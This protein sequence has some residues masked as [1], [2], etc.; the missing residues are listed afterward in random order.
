MFLNKLQHVGLR[1]PDESPDLREDGPPATYA[2]GLKG[3]DRHGKK[4][5]GLL[6][7]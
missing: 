4:T 2:P 1:I 6:F 7:G 3:F 5:R